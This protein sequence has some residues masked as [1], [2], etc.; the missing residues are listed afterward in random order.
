LTLEDLGERTKVRTVS[1]F[2]T[3]EDRDGMID[4]P[5]EV[6]L[7]ESFA[8]LDGLLERLQSR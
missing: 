5:M 2:A 8:A 7:N 4:A 6:G 1:V 3:K